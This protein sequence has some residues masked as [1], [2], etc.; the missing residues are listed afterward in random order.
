MLK[1][2][3]TRIVIT[4]TNE[5]VP[6]RNP[7]SDNLV[8]IPL[9]NSDYA[10]DLLAEIFGPDNSNVAYYADGNAG[11]PQ[12]LQHK[13]EVWGERYIHNKELV[14]Y[15]IFEK[16]LE[17]PIGFVNTG[18]SQTL[19][20]GQP[21]YTGGF[22]FK[23]DYNNSP[24]VTEALNSVYG[25]HIQGLYDQGILSSPAFIYTI[26]LDNPLITSLEASELTA[27][28]LRLN[29]A[30]QE[31]IIELLTADNDN[32]NFDYSTNTI[33]D[34]EWYANQEIGVFYYLYDDISC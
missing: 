4:P 7:Y 18:Y 17:I 13:V 14:C 33:T 10:H 29:S 11:S 27:V 8:Y 26:S 23:D 19:Y 1:G 3:K 2:Q 6:V 22:L 32:F 25:P 30:T 9:D 31:C 20:N 5:V 16:G 12:S 28:D 34:N 24:L 15:V 21:L